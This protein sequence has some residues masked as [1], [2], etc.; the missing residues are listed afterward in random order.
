MS[1]DVIDEF[2][3]HILQTAELAG[4]LSLRMVIG[5]LVCL[6]CSLKTEIAVGVVM[7]SIAN[8]IPE[9]L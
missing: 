9:H 8:V 6:T 2:V 4:A 5:T 1:N 7:S 3:E